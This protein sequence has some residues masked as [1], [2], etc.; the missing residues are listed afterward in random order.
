MKNALITLPVVAVLA[1]VAI[2]GSCLSR[3]TKA[4]TALSERRI[5]GS[6]SFLFTTE[7]IGG[8]HTAGDGIMQFDGNGGVTGVF[9]SMGTSQPLQNGTF[10]GTYGPHANAATGAPDGTVDITFTASTGGVV[11]LN[12]VFADHGNRF[13]F[14]QILDGS[15]PPG[16][17]IT[18]GWGMAQ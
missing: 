17:S 13:Q 4:G 5:T 14:S 6:Y 11:G 15:G 16:D 2:A 8:N 12:A 7:S 18:S 1:L 9:I 3:E 10:S